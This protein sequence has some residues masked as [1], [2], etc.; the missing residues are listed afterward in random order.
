M[1]NKL[2]EELIRDLQKA[3]GVDTLQLFIDTGDA[4]KTE[5]HIG[6]SAMCALTS[7]ACFLPDKG[8]FDAYG[9]F[10]PARSNLKAG[11]TGTLENSQTFWQGVLDGNVQIVNDDDD[12]E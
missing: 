9:N 7:G 4:W 1:D 8:H 2:T 12:E 5:G 11:T 6:R 10:V 3:N